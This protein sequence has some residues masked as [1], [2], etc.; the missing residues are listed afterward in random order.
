[1]NAHIA[2][3]FDD[4]HGDEGWAFSA[5]INGGELT[6]SGPIDD[7]DPNADIVEIVSAVADYLDGWGGI[8]RDDVADINNWAVDADG[9][10]KYEATQ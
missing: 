6:D 8:V 4:T 10:V 7:D 5:S 9:S 2:I 1:M 3:W